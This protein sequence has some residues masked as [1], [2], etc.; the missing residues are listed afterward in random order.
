[1]SAERQ[2]DAINMKAPHGKPSN[3]SYIVAVPYGTDGPGKLHRCW[4]D[5]KHSE[6]SKN[7][8]IHSLESTALKGPPRR[9]VS[10]HF[11]S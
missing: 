6:S 2:A 5:K 10:E 8:Q 9:D 7:Y 3:W 11:P 1:M 4:E